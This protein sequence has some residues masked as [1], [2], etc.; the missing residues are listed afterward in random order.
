MR[1]ALALWTFPWIDQKG[2]CF[3]EKRKPPVRQ[4]HSGLACF[5]ALPSCLSS[6]E[7]PVATLCPRD[8]QG[9]ERI[10]GFEQMGIFLAT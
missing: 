4:R 5:D 7:F 9:V 10:S 3:T 1:A 8:P 2:P 6:L